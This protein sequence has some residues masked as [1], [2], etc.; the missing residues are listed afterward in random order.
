MLC[1]VYLI[2]CI[3]GI[4]TIIGYWNNYQQIS[5][6]VRKAMPIILNPGDALIFHG[7]MAHYTPPNVSNRRSAQSPLSPHLYN[8]AGR[9]KPVAMI[10]SNP[11]VATFH[12]VGPRLPT[13]NLILFN[14][15]AEVRPVSLCLQSV[16]KHQ[17]SQEG[18][19]GGGE[20]ENGEAG[21]RQAPLL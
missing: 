11:A 16:Q 17:V 21:G 7:E 14:L 6:L 3:G 15:Q 10:I 8:E 18:G 13:F 19:G 5:L 12:L 4:R 1:A 9:E 20:E 2:I